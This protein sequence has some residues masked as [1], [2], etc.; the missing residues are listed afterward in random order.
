VTNE[1]DPTLW[2]GANRTSDTPETTE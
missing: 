1:C 2:V